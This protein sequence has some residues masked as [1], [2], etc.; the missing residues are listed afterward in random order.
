ML[1]QTIMHGVIMA[2]AVGIA[3]LLPEAA[4]Y[5]LFQWWPR[6]EEN[7]QL[8]F[9]SELILATAM[10]LLFHA[11]RLAW[12]GRCMLRIGRAAALVE[13][14]E[15][16]KRITLSDSIGTSRAARATRDALVLA[17]TGYDT[18]VAKG[19]HLGQ[20]IGTCYEIRVL[21][22][23]PH[24]AGA[25]CRV[26]SFDDSQASLQAHRDEFN[27]SIA[28]LKRLANC[29]KKVCLKLYDAPPFWK[30][31]IVG[32]QAW[33]QYCHDG[34]EIK[35]QP[36]YVFALRH[37]RPEQGLFPPFYVHFLNLWN[38]PR[39][40]EYDLRT[41]EL[42]FRDRVGSPTRR[43]AYPLARRANSVVGPCDAGV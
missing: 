9:A 42:V 27:A 28:Y 37:D 2:L 23:S 5:I 31:V 14:R 43:L 16:G 8:L 38:D 32:D 19:A 29:G 3:F 22:L 12:E 30:V 7:A 1:R 25:A 20:L 41:D 33:V 4:S 40:A 6:A 35:T 26:R 39:N 17:V 24:S 13:V 36:E 34:Y 21:L 10:V 15:R 11:T 18:F